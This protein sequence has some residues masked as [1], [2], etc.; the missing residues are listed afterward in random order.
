MPGGRENSAY[1]TA[2]CEDSVNWRLPRGQTALVY[3]RCSLNATCY[4]PSCRTDKVHG[5]EGTWNLRA[6]HLIA[7]LPQLSNRFGGLRLNTIRVGEITTAQPASRSTD[8]QG[9][10]PVR[11]F[12]LDQTES[13]PGCAGS[14]PESV[15][16]PTCQLGVPQDVRAAPKAGR[17]E[18]GGE[19]TRS[20]HTPP[21]T[22][23]GAP[24]LWHHLCHARL[25]LPESPG[26]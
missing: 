13:S 14:G 15:P 25:S 3:S 6:S 9:S 20:T 16:P 22:G 26:D 7:A 5:G 19:V 17:D 21:G 4:G 24:G 1:L 12:L 2:R 10:V 8:E 18:R 11:A 23:T